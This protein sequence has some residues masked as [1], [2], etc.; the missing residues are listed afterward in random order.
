M[1]TS[2]GLGTNARYIDCA[3]CN[4]YCKIHLLYTSDRMCIIN[5]CTQ[6]L[7][8]AFMQDSLTV[9]M[10]CIMLQYLRSEYQILCELLE[11]LMSVREKEDFATTLV[12]AMQRLGCAKAFLCQIVMS[13]I[14][15]LG[16][17]LCFAI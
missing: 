10:Y 4:M 17:R 8:C 2:T 12:H 5:R 3:Q 6:V 15:R 1:L 9:H 13:E 16:R 14:G 7:F 11:P